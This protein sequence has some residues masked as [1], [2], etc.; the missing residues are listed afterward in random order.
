MK[1]TPVISVIM[2]V[3]K[4]EAYIEN[5]VKSVLKQSFKDIEIICVNDCSPD[6]SL[7]KLLELQEF[8]ARVKVVDL[9]QNVGAGAARNAGI[10]IATGEYITF[11]D[12]DD[13]IED[14]LYQKAYEAC[15][16][17][18]VDQVVWGLIEDHYD[19]NNNIV[20]K[21]PI[22]SKAETVIESNDYVEKVLELEEKTLFG[23]LWN[24]MYRAEIIKK[25]NIQISDAIFYEDYFFNLDFAKEAK[26]LMTLDYIGYHYAKRPN[27]SITHQFSKDYFD[28]SY[29]RIES[30]YTFCVQRAYS[31]KDL[32]DILGNRLLRYTLS[33]LSRNS[34][35]KAGMDMAEQKRWFQAICKKEMY[36]KVVPNCTPSNIVHSVLR[37]CIAHKCSGLAVAMGNLINKIRG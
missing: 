21:V 12:A 32:Y 20:K 25:A 23:Y 18:D 6:K 1:K 36:L 16:E 33:A 24:S 15:K 13:V 10:A 3:Y 29:E 27:N 17:S 19:V 5:S 30:L 2:P 34:S 35:P 9:P 7:E 4:A 26:S 11:V 8:D 14:D 37:W 28:L 22:T 31:A